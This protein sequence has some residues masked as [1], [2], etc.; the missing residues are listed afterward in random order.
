MAVMLALTLLVVVVAM[1]RKGLG[2]RIGFVLLSGYVLY[3]GALIFEVAA[4]GS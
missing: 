1:V 2:R 4:P 3:V